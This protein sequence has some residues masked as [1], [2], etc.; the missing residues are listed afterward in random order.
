MLNHSGEETVTL[1]AS[2]LL[3]DHVPDKGE[4]LV[5]YCGWYSNR[6]RGRRRLATEGEYDYVDGETVTFFIG[7]LEF[8]LVAAGVVTPLSIA[9]T[10]DTSNSTV[11]NM[12]RLLQTQ[13][14]MGTPMMVFK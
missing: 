13:I 4:H 14:K 10:Q 7:D 11:V 5:R 9:N 1:V 8:P 3:L 2:W 12:I 6:S